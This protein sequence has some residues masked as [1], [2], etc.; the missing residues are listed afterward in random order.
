M[1][2][3][4]S[5]SSFLCVNPLPPSTLFTL[6]AVVFGAMLI[7]TWRATRNEHVQR[8]RG[9]VEPPGDVYKLMRIVYPGAFLAMFAE[10]LARGS[11][12]PS[13]STAGVAIFAAAKA[14]KWWAI[15]SLGP[16]W[17][18]RVIVVPGA[19]LVAKGPYRWLRHPNYIGVVGELAGVA[20]MTG[21]WVS[22][23][24]AIATFGA[25]LMKRIAVE[26]RAL[27]R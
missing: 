26:E 7:E 20:M 9:G 10:G 17:T 27:E 16:F 21:A 2:R 25:L 4:N 5:V 15:L 8:T 24:A 22:G 14:L 11:P 1:Y 3:Q 23:V 13:V 6:A 19:A 12:S 18:F